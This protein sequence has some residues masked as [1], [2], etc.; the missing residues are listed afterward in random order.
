MF[1][2]TTFAKFCVLFSFVF[3]APLLYAEREWRTITALDWDETLCPSKFLFQKDMSEREDGISVIKIS[4]EEKSQIDLLGNSVANLIYIATNFGEVV[5]VTAAEKSWIKWGIENLYKPHAEI[6]NKVSV[7]STRDVNEVELQYFRGSKK[8][9]IFEKIVAE[10]HSKYRKKSDPT[11][12][13]LFNFIS[14]GDGNT[15]ALAAKNLFS[16]NSSRE[17]RVLSKSI[18]LPIVITPEWMK[19]NLDQLTDHFKYIVADPIPLQVN[20]FRNLP[21]IKEL[22]DL[23]KS[24]ILP[25][26]V[27]N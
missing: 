10:K 3:H 27:V 13:I 20:D 21:R 2:S 22:V 7:F 26:L 16:L 5:I 24:D 25:H 18:K 8:Q 12:K 9:F 6:L 23:E 14:I 15:E 1:R 19:F 11:T 17:I 4:K